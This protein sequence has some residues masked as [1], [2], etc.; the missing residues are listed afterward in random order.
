MKNAT[1]IL[2]LLLGILSCNGNQKKEKDI[3]VQIIKPQSNLDGKII[4]EFFGCGYNTTINKKEINLYLPRERELNQIN[5][6]LNFSGL[7]SNFIIYSAPIENAVATIIDNKRY[8]LYDPRLLSISDKK[9]GNYWSSMSIL[10]HEIGHHLSGHTLSN[11]ARLKAELEADKY[12]GYVLYKLGA[13]K[14]EATTAINNFG[15]DYDTNS[16]P[17]KQKRIDAI[18]QGWDDASQQRYVSAIPPPPEDDNDDFYIDEFM[19]ED[20]VSKEALAA[21]NFGDLLDSDIDILEGIVIDVTREDPSGGGR[22]GNF[23]NPASDFNLVIT[24]ELTRA[25]FTKDNMNKLIGKRIKFHLLDYLHMFNIERSWLEKILKPG[26]KIRFK[27]IYYGYGSSDIVYLKKLNRSGYEKDAN[28]DNTY[29]VINNRAHFFKKPN[30]SSIKSA[31]LIRGEKFVGK[32]K[33]NGFVYT[34]FTNPKG[35]QTSGWIN[36][37]DVNTKE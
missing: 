30:L 35:Q 17:S 37:E 23:N 25:V 29:L 28:A 21:P 27:T 9:S 4:G 24:I 19:A 26:R 6:I 13:S 2:I 20:L 32:Y 16:H 18:I 8:I 33:T 14:L 11:G 31:Y 1:F 34:D 12:S 36:L 7:N 15:T 22:A 10:A 3:H 5:S